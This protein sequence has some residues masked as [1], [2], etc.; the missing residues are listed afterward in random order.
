M[1]STGGP[2]TAGRWMVRSGCCVAAS[3]AVDEH[4]IYK[5]QGTKQESIIFYLRFL[6]F[7]AKETTG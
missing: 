6:V 7:M 1:S 4:Q 3:T 5:S 2:S